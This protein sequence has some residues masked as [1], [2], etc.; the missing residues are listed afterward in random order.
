MGAKITLQTEKR[1]L[2][3]RFIIIIE[4]LLAYTFSIFPADGA[5]SDGYRNADYNIWSSECFQFSSPE[6]NEDFQSYFFVCLFST[7]YP[8]TPPITEA[9]KIPI[10]A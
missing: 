6:A 1:M 2:Y 8:K 5:D 9:V 3:F 10:L 4:V 7:I